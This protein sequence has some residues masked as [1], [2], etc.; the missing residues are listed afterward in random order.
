MLVGDV[1]EK[2]NGKIH[3]IASHPQKRMSK[4][5]SSLLGVARSML[6][7]VLEMHNGQ[8]ERR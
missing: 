2:R 3:L 8:S 4:N 5:Q 7:T 1:K 6:V